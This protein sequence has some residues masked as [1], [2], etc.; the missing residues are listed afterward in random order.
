MSYATLNNQF[1]L[2]PPPSKSVFSTVRD[3]AGRAWFPDF[4]KEQDPVGSLKD[5][6]EILF[7]PHLQQSTFV[8][9]KVLS[10]LTAIIGVWIFLIILRR[11]WEKSFWLFR[12]VKRS[13]GTLIVPNAITAFVA[14]ESIFAILL[15]ALCWEVVAWYQYG[16]SPKYIILWIGLTWLPLIL[17]A[18]CTTVGVIYARPNALSFVSPQPGKPHGLALRMGVTPTTVNM[19]VFCIPLI[20]TASVVVPAA[21]AQMR[22]SRAF[23]HHRRWAA[24]IT[25]GE[26]LSRELLLEAQQ[27]W[28]QV[29]DA[30]YMISICMAV[31]EAWVCGLFVCYC[32]AGTSLI[33]MLRK[34]LASLKSFKQNRSFSESFAGEN[35]RTAPRDAFPNV[36]VSSDSHQR[37]D[38]SDD[39]EK[40]VHGTTNANDKLSVQPPLRSLSTSSA[41]SDSATLFSGNPSIERSGSLNSTANGK[42]T[43]TRR[44]VGLE[45]EDIAEE[46]TRSMYFTAEELKNEN[47]PSNS[48][49]P[50]VRP[51]AFERPT[52]AR[53]VSGT[54]H[55]HKRYLEKFYTNFV[56]QFVGLL[57]CILF[58]VIFVG[59][60]V[61]TWYSAWEA[62]D[63]ATA[64]QIALLVVC[65]VTIILASVIIFAILSRTYEPVLSNLNVATS[66]RSSGGR[67][68]R[69]SVT[70]SDDGSV[71]QPRSSRRL[72]GAMT[73]AASALSPRSN[74]D[75]RRSQEFGL[76]Q[77]KTQRRGSRAGSL[78][79]MKRTSLH[80]YAELEGEQ[81]SPDLE[82]IPCSPKSQ[83]LSLRK[84]TTS[85]VTPDLEAP[86]TPSELISDSHKQRAFGGSRVS[87]PSKTSQNGVIVEQTVSTIVEHPVMEEYYRVE[88]PARAAARFSP[89]R[90]ESWDTHHTHSAYFNEGDPSPIAR[91]NVDSDWVR[92]PATPASM[93]APPTSSS[94]KPLMTEAQ[95]NWQ[96]S[97][98]SF[99]PRSYQMSAP[100]QG[101]DI[102][103]HRS[104]P[105]HS[106]R[107]AP[108]PRS[109]KKTSKNDVGLGIAVA[110]SSSSSPS[111]P[112]TAPQVWASGQPDPALVQEDAD[113]RLRMAI[114]PY[115][116]VQSNHI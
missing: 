11:V 4:T 25:P 33:A 84:A 16:R 100:S 43:R 98:T 107:P 60:L 46:Q 41:A 15:I 94:T 112:W 73:W 26:T 30:A 115:R 9:L 99:A 81:H 86:M 93:W 110:P 55:S 75:H 87:P 40:Q 101:E 35:D 102:L 114:H 111:P 83:P 31:W 79:G 76:E 96:G 7:Y 66:S 2:P 56:V 37:G 77:V 82:A 88:R 116:V 109:A 48:F 8:Q 104:R 32:L 106:L 91:S 36:I 92:T 34:Q 52:Q 10:V 95:R 20:Q 38:H 65:W 69:L 6:I 1:N 85:N 103:L 23:E 5:F 78:S 68:R 80:T 28:F 113:M 71:G 22:F 90:S 3:E 47:Q 61:T 51:S 89:S 29:L 50:P 27:I 64:L 17:G 21:L 97:A 24:S 57:L 105:D 49:F 54:Q 70:A 19:F 62:N 67:T 59:K 12:L 108:R 14:I 13:N 58:F 53:S 42:T 44:M 18:W 72:S 45:E 39:V 74:P 63:F